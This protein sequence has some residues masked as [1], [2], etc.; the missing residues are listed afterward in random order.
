MV[1]SAGGTASGG[2]F[3]IQYAESGVLH[4][5]KVTTPAGQS[6]LQWLESMIN[7][8]SIYL[9][10]TQSATRLSLSSIMLFKISLRKKGRDMRI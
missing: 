4:G 7:V 6:E 10:T 5:S 2:I 1:L 8:F 9:Y 3:V